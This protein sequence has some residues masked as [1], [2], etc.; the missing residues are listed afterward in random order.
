MNDE[1]KNG[2]SKKINATAFTEQLSITL[3]SILCCLNMR[4]LGYWKINITV[5]RTK[6]DPGCCLCKC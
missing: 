1:S 2:N 4:L 5:F 6:S 3:F